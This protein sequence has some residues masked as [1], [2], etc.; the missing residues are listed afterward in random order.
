MEGVLEESVE[1]A[2]G[3][4]YGVADDGDDT[5]RFMDTGDEF[6]EFAV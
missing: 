4:W 6:I 5:W 2:D 3:D 1:G